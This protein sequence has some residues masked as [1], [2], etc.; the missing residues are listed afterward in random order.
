MIT[1]GSNSPGCSHDWEYLGTEK[2]GGI[3]YRVY[4]CS[5]CGYYDRQQA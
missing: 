4:R 2:Q 5:K 3:T 1:F